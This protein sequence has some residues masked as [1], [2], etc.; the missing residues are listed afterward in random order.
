[1]TIKD[2]LAAEL[3]DAMKAKDAPRRDVGLDRRL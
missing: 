2:E 3:I 1:M